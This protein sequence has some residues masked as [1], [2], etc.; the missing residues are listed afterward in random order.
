MDLSL[1]RIAARPYVALARKSAQPMLRDGR[2]A[3]P[4]V[5]HVAQRLDFNAGAM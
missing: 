5:E 2:C 4:I 1:Q 3:L